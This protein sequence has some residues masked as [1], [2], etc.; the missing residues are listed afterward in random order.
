MTTTNASR[1]QLWHQRLGHQSKQVLTDANAQF[2]LSIPVSE[3]NQ[4][5]QCI[6]CTQG[7]AIRKSIHQH[8]DPQYKATEPLQTLHADLVGPM[9]EVKNNLHP[10]CPSIGNHLYALIVTDEFTHAIFVN[11]LEKKSDAAQALINLI[12]YLQN[13]TGR[14]ILRFHSDGGGEFRGAN[15]QSFLK[16][17][18]IR[19]TYTTA[20]T[21]QHNGMA[22]RMNRTLFELTRTLL[23]QASAP[24]EMWGEALMWAAHLYNVTPHPISNNQS[25]FQLLFNYRYNIQKLRV[26]GCDS[27]VQLLPDKQSK[28]QSRTWTGVFVGFHKETSSYRIMNPNTKAI[29]NSNDVHFDEQSF[30]LIQRIKGT[31]A[32][33]IYVHI[34]PFSASEQLQDDELW[35]ELPPS[36]NEIEVVSEQEVDS[37]SN[38]EH[39]TISA[40]PA[41]TDE[42]DKPVDSQSNVVDETCNYPVAKSSSDADETDDPAEYP[43]HEADKAD[44]NADYNNPTDEYPVSETDE[45]ENADYPANYPANNADEIDNSEP[46]DYDSAAQ[47]DEADEVDEADA[48]IEYGSTTDAARNSPPLP[49]ELQKLTTMYSSWKEKPIERVSNNRTRYGRAIVPP[50]DRPVASDPNAYDPTD[51]HQ[52]LTERVHLFTHYDEKREYTF[53]AQVISNEPKHYKDAINSPEAAEWKSGMQDEIHSMNRLGVWTIIECPKGIKLLKGRWVFKN[54]L[55]DNNQLIRRKARFVA[56]GFLQVYGRDFF[57]THSPV[58]KMK[59]IKMM[60]SLVAQRDMEIQQLDFDTAFLNASV[61]EDIYMEQPEG[62]HVGGPNMVCKLNKAIYGLKQASR[63]WNRTID[64]FMRKLGYTALRSDPCVYVKTS[65]TNQLIILCLYVDDTMIA[66]DQADTDEWIEDKKKIAHTYAIKDLGECQWILN[67]KVVRDRENRTITLSQQAYIERM[68]SHYGMGESRTVD[69]PTQVGDLWKPIDGTEPIPLSHTQSELY[70]SLVGALLYAAN[71]TRIDIAFIVG[72]LCR[73]T[74]D[75]CIH[76]LEAAKRVLR[77][78]R[79]TSTFCLIFGQSQPN[80]TQTDISAYSDAD[81][82]GSKKDGKSTTG[83]VIRFNGDII[84]W[85]SKKQGSVA[86]SSAEAEY[87]AIAEVVKEVLWYRS[88]I[89]EVLGQRICGVIHCDNQAAIQLSD[90]DSIHDRSKHIHLRYHFIRDEIQKNHIRIVWISTK[91]QQADILTKGLGTNVFT[92][93][94]KLLLVS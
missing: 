3:L 32:K 55:G 27:Y 75:S 70:R 65:K 84:N 46:I 62:F 14:L 66:F 34:N 59:S 85:L 2:K 63:E 33:P 4:L 36:P 17:N 41:M 94:R 31:T 19:F 42:T 56:K 1:T 67:M 6:V 79:C 58:A 93:L 23:I 81:W 50:S 38:D 88:W 49:R 35:E 52:A 20:S 82:G 21:P 57:E 30:K 28:I 40:Y 22:E 61:E 24:E 83:C 60:L 80:L 91:D 44:S 92:Q 25:P 10:R 37:I 47:A 76:H 39:R 43:A 15:F 8:A 26:W 51:I 86:Q 5:G 18:D 29:T 78:L 7:K 54:K 68:L 87:M 11:L 89:S 13:Q 71:I 69:N 16:S 73:Y 12:K 90:N 9:S 72:Q 48:G 45:A 74:S 77:Y 53:L 64:K